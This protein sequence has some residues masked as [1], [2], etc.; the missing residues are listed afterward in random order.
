MGVMRVIYKIMPT[1]PGEEIIKVIINKV[2]ELSNKLNIKLHDFKAEPIAFGLYSLKILVSMPE[3]EDEILNK[4]EEGVKNINE[5]ES[6]EVV[7][8]TRA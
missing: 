3:E 1:A 6:L 4:F 5:V 7:G 8:M 2:S